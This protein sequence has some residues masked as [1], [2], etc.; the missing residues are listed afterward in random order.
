MAKAHHSD[1]FQFVVEGLA[2]LNEL[3][4]LHLVPLLYL[5]Q[6]CFQFLLQP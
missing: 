3:A 6:L 4:F 1:L 5:V 2:G